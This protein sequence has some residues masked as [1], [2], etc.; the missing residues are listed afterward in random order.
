[1]LD[2]PNEHLAFMV[3]REDLESMYKELFVSF[4]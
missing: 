4:P 2:I 1:M 3:F